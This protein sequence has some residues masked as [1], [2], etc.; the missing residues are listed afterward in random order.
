MRISVSVSDRLR[1]TMLTTP[2]VAPTNDRP[3][4]IRSDHT[5]IAVYDRDSFFLHLRTR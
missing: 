4:P 3:D 1:F 2:E 5:L